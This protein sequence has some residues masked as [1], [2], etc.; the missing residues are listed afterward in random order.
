MLK[1]IP[2]SIYGDANL[3]LSVCASIASGASISR[4][5]LVKHVFPTFSRNAKISIPS[6]AISLVGILILALPKKVGNACLTSTRRDI[7]Q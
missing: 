1:N 7:S 4:L 2:V 6:Y 5:V 3:V